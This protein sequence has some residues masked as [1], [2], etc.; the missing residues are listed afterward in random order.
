MKNIHILSTDKPSRIAYYQESTSYNEPILQLVSHTSSDYKYQN[1]Y[2]TSEEEIKINDYITDGYLVWQWKDNSSLLGR[3]K[4]VLTTNQDLITCGVQSV[5]DKFLEWVI[6]NPTCD[7]VKTEKWL[8]DEGNV[9]YSRIL[10]KE[11]RFEDSFENP[12]DIMN[13]SNIM[14]GVQEVTINQFPLESVELFNQDNKSLG[15]INELQLLDVQCQIAERQLEGYYA[16]M[17]N[18]KCEIDNCGELKDWDGVTFH[19]EYMLLT[20][21]RRIQQRHGKNKIY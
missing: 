20:K 1:I 13:I 8:N 6:K 5:D 4:V 9:I 21:L 12:T 19:R 11:P 15:L 17:G 10:P 16:M 14:F 2:I 18:L 7:F 3:K